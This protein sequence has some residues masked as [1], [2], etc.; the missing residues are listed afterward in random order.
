[1]LSSVKVSVNWQTRK[2]EVFFL[3]KRTS[4]S[5]KKTEKV[6]NFVGFFLFQD[7]V[8]S[9]STINE[10]N[11]SF[12]IKESKQENSLELPESPSP[13]LRPDYLPNPKKIFVSFMVQAHFPE[14]TSVCWLHPQFPNSAFLFLQCFLSCFFEHIFV[15]VSIKAN[16]TAFFYFKQFSSL[17]RVSMNYKRTFG[18]TQCETV[19]ITY[20]GHA[21]VSTKFTYTR[22]LPGKMPL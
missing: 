4:S 16:D 17:L 22:K 11:Q 14:I 20:F 1:M 2:K 18:G 19:K 5:T 9:R 21:D 3:R 13:S 8:S 7:K 6:N 10:E 12:K 15:C